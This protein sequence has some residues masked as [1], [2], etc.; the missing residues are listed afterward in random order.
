MMDRGQW[1]KRAERNRNDGVR[2]SGSGADV[3]RSDGVRD[4][5]GGREDGNDGSRDQREAGT[6]RISPRDTGGDRVGNQA[7][8]APAKEFKPH[9]LKEHVAS[10]V[11]KKLGRE[12]REHMEDRDVSQEDKVEGAFALSASARSALKLGI[13]TAIGLLAAFTGKHIVVD[14]QTVSQAIEGLN[15]T[16]VAIGVVVS[17]LTTVYGAVRNLWKNWDKVKEN[18]VKVSHNSE[19]L[20]FDFAPKDEENGFMLRSLLV[21]VAFAAVV[22]FVM[23]PAL[24]GCG[25]M[26]S[27]RQ[28]LVDQG[29]PVGQKIAD[30]LNEAQAK[31]LDGALKYFQKRKE[32]QVTNIAKW[33]EG[34]TDWNPSNTFMLESLNLGVTDS[35]NKIRL[36]EGLIA[37]ANAVPTGPKAVAPAGA[38][39]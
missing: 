2:E 39:G 7:P 21:A 6:V 1:A 35:E 12:L 16:L 4:G 24:V 27:A 3:G 17:A 19:G 38:G 25:T 14:Q 9:G 8:E 23:A 15:T 29:S 28:S 30:V 22:C 32:V 13:V 11:G 10:A 18:G 20:L 36:I 33:K 5:A 34:V 26:T 31:T 37:S